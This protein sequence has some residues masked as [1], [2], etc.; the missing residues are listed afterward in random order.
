MRILIKIFK[1]TIFSAAIS[2]STCVIA[3]FL[4]IF[5]IL[6]R[7]SL[8]NRQVVSPIP[9]GSI[10]DIA[11]SSPDKNALPPPEKTLVDEDSRYQ[12]ALVQLKLIEEIEEE[13]RKSSVRNICEMICDEPHFKAG[14]L[15]F[16]SY[17]NTQGRKAF[18]DVDFRLQ[19]E[20][21]LL[22]K[23][24]FPPET[25]QVVSEISSYESQGKSM[26]QKL[27]ATLRMEGLVLRELILMGRRGPGLNEQNRKLSAVKNFRKQCTARGAV[28]IKAACSLKKDAFSL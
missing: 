20:S 23:Q 21:F 15:D 24:L 8:E 1:Y 27:F 4:G 2:L 5:F 25:L 14:H 22:I 17:Y 7:E 3:L 10:S 28:E 11:A 6:H 16:I 26:P 9:Q 12:K 18:E 13:A 19:L